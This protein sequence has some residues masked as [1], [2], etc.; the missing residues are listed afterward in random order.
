MQGDIQDRRIAAILPQEF[1]DGFL[2]SKVF[3][4]AALAGRKLAHE[5]RVNG[6]VPVRDAGDFEELRNRTVAH[7][8]CVLAKRTFGLYGIGGNRSFDN[9]LRRRGDQ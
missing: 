6:V 9:D 7:V 2:G 8:T 3:D 4:L 1:V 5:R